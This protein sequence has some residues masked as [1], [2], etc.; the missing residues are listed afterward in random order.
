M[1]KLTL[2]TLAFSAAVAYASAAQAYQGATQQCREYTR[3]INIGGQ[4]QQGV[5][6]ACLQADGSW[7]IISDAQVPATI[8]QPQ[9]IERVVVRE[10]IYVPSPRYGY[11]RHRGFY[12]PRNGLSISFGNSWGHRPHYKHRRHY[13]HRRAYQR[14]HDR[15]H[16]RVHRGG[17]YGSSGH[18]HK[19]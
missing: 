3:P 7:R 8:S 10:P 18:Y 2:T 16:S 14:G 11:H 6:T 13:N 17:R 12:G 4:I 1:K 19:R 15:F 9:V 5:G